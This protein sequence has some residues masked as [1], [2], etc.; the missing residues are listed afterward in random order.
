MVLALTPAPDLTPQFCLR[1]VVAATPS[2]NHFHPGDNP[3]E[4]TLFDLGVVDDLQIG[5]SSG[6]CRIGSPSGRSTLLI[7]RVR[8]TPHCRT[9]PIRCRQV[10]CRRARRGDGNSDPST[11]FQRL[12]LAPGGP[13]RPKQIG[14]PQRVA[15]RAAAS[16][17]HRYPFQRAICRQID[18]PSRA[19]IPGAIWWR[20]TEDGADPISVTVDISHSDFDCAAAHHP[21]RALPV[22]Y[23]L[24]NS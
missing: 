14:D 24:F 11:R 8:E 22:T 9:P 16:L 21:A 3:T 15:R 2:P 5:S 4:K 12:T 19:R 10:Q 1:I 20:R 23:R 6:E 13:T 17:F 18:F 7:S